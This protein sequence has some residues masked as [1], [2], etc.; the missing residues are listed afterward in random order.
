MPKFE[1][2][3][4]APDHFTFQDEMVKIV[5]R[6]KYTHGKPVRGT[7]VISVYGEN[8]DRFDQSN[9]ALATKTIV[10]DGREFIE[11]DMKNE[12]KLDK[13]KWFG[14]GRLKFKAEFTET[15]TG[16]T[17]ST[18]KTVKIYKNAYVITTNLDH[19][20][21]KPDTKVDVTVRESFLIWIYHTGLCIYF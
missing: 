15:L 5:V 9:L 18:E 7:V 16:L 12:I 21:L 3:I 19:K 11:F 17:Q 10:M 20:I 6:A 8:M 13:S 2:A 4:E 14:D 1:V